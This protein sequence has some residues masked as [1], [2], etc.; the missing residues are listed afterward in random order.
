MGQNPRRRAKIRLQKGE[1]SLNYTEHYQLNQ[2][3]PTDRVLREDFNED[4]R[5]IEA[6]LGAIQQLTVRFITGSYIGDGSTAAREFYL[7]AR[8]KFLLL[9]RDSEGDGSSFYQSAFIAE[10]FQYTFMEAGK[11]VSSALKLLTFT[12]TGFTLQSGELHAEKGFNRS[13]KQ[14][15]YLA[16]CQ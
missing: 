13:G 10:D 8:P 7:G 4:N 14:Y 11:S 5:K 16:L 3:E 2:W 12:D 6:A 1:S 15:R 9:C